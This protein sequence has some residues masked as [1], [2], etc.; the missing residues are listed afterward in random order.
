MFIA[1]VHEKHGNPLRRTAL[2][3]L[4]ARTYSSLD[5]QAQMERGIIQWYM[6]LYKFFMLINFYKNFLKK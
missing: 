5:K 3:A 4:A 2:S 1:Y 6:L